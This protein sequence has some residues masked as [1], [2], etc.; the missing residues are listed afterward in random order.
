MSCWRASLVMTNN[1]AP[2]CINMQHDF[3]SC[4]PQNEGPEKMGGRMQPTTFVELRRPRLSLDFWRLPR[5][6]V[7]LDDPS[8]LYARFLR[9]ENKNAAEGGCGPCFFYVLPCRNQVC[10]FLGKLAR[11]WTL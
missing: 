9:A 11:G 5:S 7:P 4:Q 3:G 2:S 6:R 8:R 1:Y 10:N